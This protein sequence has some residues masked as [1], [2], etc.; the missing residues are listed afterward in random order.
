MKFNNAK[1]T[2]SSLSPMSQS[3]QHGAPKLEGENYDDYDIR[4]WREKMHVEERD[5]KKTV[6]I[7]HVAI[8]K[9]LIEAAKY[10]KKQIPGQGKATWTQKFASGVMVPES[11][12]IE[13]D[14]EEAFCT[15]ISANADGIRGRASSGKRVPRRFPTFMSWQSTFEVMV[16]DPAI[17]EP[18]FKEMVEIA[19]IFVGLGQYRPEQQ[20]TNGRFRLVR[21]DWQDNRSFV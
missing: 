21:M 2:I 12:S 18:V 4:T 11:A 3:R 9:C 13:R 5:G 7:P 10:S 17:T 19:G 14:P 15:T 8:H 6:V 16:L 20:G 1:I